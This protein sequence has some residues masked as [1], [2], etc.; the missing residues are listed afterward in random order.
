METRESR[1]ICF[2]IVELLHED[3]EFV[4][5]VMTPLS[6]QEKTELDFFIYLFFLL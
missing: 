4:E 2:K 5:A 1:D 6:F 3:L